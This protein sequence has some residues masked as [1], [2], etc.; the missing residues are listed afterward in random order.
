MQLL[1]IIRYMPQA[2]L[3]LM[4]DTVTGRRAQKLTPRDIVQAQLDAMAAVLINHR[5]SMDGRLQQR[6]HC[7]NRRMMAEHFGLFVGGERV[8]CRAL[9]NQLLHEED[10]SNILPKPVTISE[11]TKDVFSCANRFQQE[12]MGTALL[13]S[14]LFYSFVHKFQ[15]TCKNFDR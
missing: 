8:S 5:L 7:V 13:M 14:A 9:V 4:E 1:E 6:I 15:D 10:T 11:E 2:P 12:Y 3:C